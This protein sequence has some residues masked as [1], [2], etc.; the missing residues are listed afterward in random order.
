[1]TEEARVWAPV[2]GGV[3]VALASLYGMLR[4]HRQSPYQA[5]AERVV[6]LEE[7]VDAL[8]KE[9]DEAREERD[10]ARE[11]VDLLTTERD[12]LRAQLQR[13]RAENRAYITD[14][15]RA[16]RQGDELTTP[17][18]WYAAEHTD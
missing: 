18:P 12:M 5:L 4:S 8:E 14:L 1:M 3:L 9:R 15:I 16:A 6:R 11:A 10:A 2:I 13:E 7:R 17:P